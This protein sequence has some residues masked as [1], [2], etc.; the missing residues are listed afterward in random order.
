MSNLDFDFEK[1]LKTEPDN[2]GTEVVIDIG[3]L[4]L[5]GCLILVI[6]G[7]RSRKNGHQER[8]KVAKELIFMRIYYNKVKGIIFIECP[9]LGLSSIF[10][11]QICVVSFLSNN[12]NYFD[13]N[14]LKK[15][16]QSKQICWITSYCL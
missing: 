14:F 5:K 8:V 3:I 12:K 15:K 16:S 6:I 2:C 11:T 7:E 4:G 9:I 1:K 13:I 10:E